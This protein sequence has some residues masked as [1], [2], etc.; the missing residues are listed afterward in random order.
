VVD[1]LL[2][3]MALISIGS[4]LAFQYHDFPCVECVLSHSRIGLLF[5]LSPLPTCITPSGTVEASPE[6]E[7][8]CSDPASIPSPLFEVHV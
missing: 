8:F 6:E 7:A 5:A 4:W 2:R 1:S 3:C